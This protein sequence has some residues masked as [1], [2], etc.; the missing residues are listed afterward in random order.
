ME[1]EMCAC[2]GGRVRECVCVRI[3]CVRFHVRKS[4]RVWVQIE[5]W[6]EKKGVY[7]YS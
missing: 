1:V 7:K 4:M 5:K 2:V 6:E 3:L